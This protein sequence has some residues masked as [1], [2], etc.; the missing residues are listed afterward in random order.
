MNYILYLEEF[1]GFF[2]SALTVVDASLGSF[3]FT[4]F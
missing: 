1:G 2:V 4:I 3:D